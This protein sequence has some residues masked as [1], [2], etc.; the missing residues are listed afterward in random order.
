MNQL[1]I[2]KTRKEVRQ[3]ISFCKETK[4]ASIDFE[5]TGLKFHSEY[6]FPL[7]LGVSFQQGSSWVIP[8]KHKESPFLKEQEWVDVLQEFGRGVM[9]DWE[10]TKIGWNFKFEYKWFMK[11]GI[12]PKGR[13]FDGMLAKY[14][15]D[16]ERPHGLKETVV[17]LF[18]KYANYEKKIKGRKWEDIPLDELSAYCGLDTD[19]TLRLMNYFEPK[20]I[21]LGFYNL[22]RNLLMTATRVLAESEFRGANIDV[23]YLDGL[24]KTYAEK[25][26]E[27]EKTLR[28]VPSLLKYES[29]YR[30]QHLRKL[31]EEI[32]LEIEKIKQENTKNAATLI[33]NR[34]VKISRLSSGQLTDKEKWENLNFNSPTQ[35]QDFFFTSKAGLKL[36]PSKLTDSGKPST[37]EESLEV[38]RPADKSGLIDALLEYRGL[39][40][41]NSTYIVGVREKITPNNKIHSSFKLHGTVT[42]RSSSEDPNLQNI[43]RNTTSSDIKKMFIPPKGY[44]LLEVDYSQAELRVVAELAHDKAM[45]DIFK[46]DFNIHVATAC[47]MNGGLEL[48]DK[49]KGILKKA[50]LMS[51]EE[52]KLPENKEYLFWSK[53]K[54]RAKTVNFGILYGQT[55]R[56][57]SIELECTE[58]EALE[59]IHQWYKAYPQVTKWIKEQQ[60]FVREHGYVLSMFGR[61]RRLHN[62]YS[63]NKWIRLEA[64][65]QAVNTPIQGT[66]SDFGF[67]SQVV[68]REEIMRGNLPKDLA[69]VYT[70]HDSIGYYIKPTDIHSVVPKLVKICD[71]P[72]TK[73]YFGFQLNDVKMKVSVEVGT[74]W[75]SITSYDAWEDYTKWV[76]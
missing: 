71:N 9:E 15:L 38:M 28:K 52:L 12:I 59:F 70:V 8:L 16:E 31:V 54:K 68:V 41:L 32:E 21:K 39:T 35:L 4:T 57:L 69:Q 13:L 74:T 65:R 40:K 22:F 30:K 14:C 73:K 25:I 62:I 55:E 10:I 11:Y 46:R 43:P 2:V 49:V 58:Q 7:C 56:K 64:E 63:D 42:G 36:K 1:K 18:P 34:E 72:E 3:L 61:K 23:P 20:L 24:V 19:L 76:K 53:Q 26:A 60:R 29:Y 66:A 48:Y 75:E 27:C 47:K 17:K 5:T 6:E 67:L 51:G 37:D 45:I 33:H 44:L 50:D